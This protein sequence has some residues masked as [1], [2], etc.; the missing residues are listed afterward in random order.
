[1][2]DI[3]FLVKSLKYPTL[4]FNILNFVSFSTST[5]RSGLSENYN[6]T[7]VEPPQYAIFISTEL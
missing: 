2:L 3:M 5:T 7:I 6:T 4:N 1:M